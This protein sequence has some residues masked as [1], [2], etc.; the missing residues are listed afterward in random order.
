MRCQVIS[1]A[2]IGGN[3]WRHS[4]TGEAQGGAIYSSATVRASECSFAGDQALSGNG[5]NPTDGR[6]G[7]IYNLGLAVLNGC[8]LTSNLAK[9][10]DAADLSGLHFPAGH[11]LG[12]AVFNTSQLVMT[13]CTTALNLAQG[14]GEY[15]V[16]GGP[17]IGVVGTGAGGGVYGASNGL[18]TAVNVT[19]ASNSV[20]QG[21]GWTNNGFADGANIAVTNGTISLLNSIIAYPGTNHNAWGTITDAGY[22]MSSDGSANFN[23]GLSFNFTDPLLQ[24]LADNGGPTLTMALS[25][26]SPAVDSG[27]SVGAPLTDQRGVTRPVGLGFD[28]GAFELIQRPILTIGRAG[29]GVWLSFQAQAGATYVLQ[30]STTLTNWTDTE[31]IGPYASGTQFNRTNN[32]YRVGVLE[33]VEGGPAIDFFRL[34][35]Q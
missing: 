20:A 7:A 18:F 16:G 26:D 3:A 27:T 5:S 23:S 12:G 22:N 29:N 24:G 11:G 35:V 10:G 13:N 21:H 19:I 17:G 34:R 33:R 4:G 15:D 25:A 9:G 1:N 2:A 32:I 28:M 8:S 14:G 6:G 30:N 31:I